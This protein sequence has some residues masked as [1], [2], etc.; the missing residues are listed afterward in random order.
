MVEKQVHEKDWDGIVF[1]VGVMGVLKM[2]CLA[3]RVEGLVL[4]GQGGEAVD[5][6]PVGGVRER[7]GHDLCSCSRSQ[8]GWMERIG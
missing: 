7:A 5:E 3:G 2:T 4:L 8:Q 1:L 6:R